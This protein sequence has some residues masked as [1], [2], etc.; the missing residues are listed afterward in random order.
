M[1]IGALMKLKV[2]CLG[3]PAGTV[4]VV[5]Y[6][7]GDGFQVIFPNGEYDG[8]SVPDESE[9]FLEEV[10]FA[11]SVADYAFK[12]VIRLSDDYRNGVFN[13]ALGR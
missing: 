6:D 10:G 2:N 3:N 8:F 1:R 7:Y 12:S 11:P 5:Y 9:Q 13:K 4:G